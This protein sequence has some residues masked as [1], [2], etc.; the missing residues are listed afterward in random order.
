M[1]DVLYINWSDDNNL[2]I[3]II[4]EQHRGII[5][6]INSLYYFIQ[7]GQG[8]EILESI[9]IMLI[10]YTEIHFATEE[11]IIAKVNYPA[12]AEHKALHSTLI[13]KTK[14]LSLDINKGKDATNVLKFL[15]DWWLN[16]INK[17][18]KKYVQFLN[19]Q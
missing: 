16:H 15:R 8:E 19:L 10:Q 2:G 18:D 12:F 4:D 13:G 7:M 5:S 3:P 14:R 6:T 1:Q 11:G 9:L 17:E